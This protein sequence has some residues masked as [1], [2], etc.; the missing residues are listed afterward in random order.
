[1]QDLFS[2]TPQPQTHQEIKSIRLKSLEISNFKGIKHLLIN[3][4]DMVN[5]FGGNATGKTTIV[6]AFR[7]L[8]FDKDSTGRSDFEIKPLDQNNKTLPGIEVQ[9][10]GI[11]NVNGRQK[12]LHKILR[13]KWTKKRGESTKVFTGNETIYEIDDI[14]VKASEYAAEISGML[15]EQL[16]KMLTDPLYFG[17]LMS[18]QDRRKILLTM[19]EPI[20]DDEVMN[21]DSQLL[22]LKSLI[23]EGTT[24]EKLR[25]SIA[26]KKATINNELKFIP[27]RISECNNAIVN[28]NIEETEVRI[29]QLESELKKLDTDISGLSI[30]NPVTEQLRIDI[31]NKKNQLAVLKDRLTDEYRNQRSKLSTHISELK[32]D[33]SDK[34]ATLKSKKYKVSVFEPEIA[35]TEQRI[36]KFRTDWQEKAKEQL[37]IT[38]SFDCP[39]CKRRL[40]E[41][42]IANKTKILTENFNQARAEALKK[43]NADGKALKEENEKRKTEI[44]ELKSQIVLLDEEIITAKKVLSDR[45]IELHNFELE[46]VNIASTHPEVVALI[47]DIDALSSTVIEDNNKTTIEDLQAKRISI[48]TELDGLKKKLTQSETNNSLTKRIGELSDQERKLSQELANLERQEIL[49][50]TFIRAK[51]EILEQKINGMF[52]IVKFKMFNEQINGGLSETCVPTIYG[53]PFPDANNAA[54]YNAG[55]DIINALSKKY[56]VSA[57]IFIDNREGINDIIPTDAQII[58]LRVSNDEKLTVR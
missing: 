54:K 17:Q 51:S 45:E 50:E 46:N 19:A 48:R 35:I 13:E 18:W 40:E 30:V 23:D 55:I 7:W 38:E 22:S 44:A 3:F 37:I 12:K 2:G 4:E 27:A 33:I 42:T 8:S 6:D 36:E 47:A 25:A 15:N 10:I 58:N 41:S 53:V 24:V 11:I 5:I 56:Q 43:I 26:S 9:V 20:S 29:N 16:F 34:E 52:T 14:P 49:T 32:N 57:P 39:T 28:V 21:S 31:N 1:M